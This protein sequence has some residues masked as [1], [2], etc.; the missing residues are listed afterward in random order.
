MTRDRKRVLV[1]GFGAFPGAPINPTEALVESLRAL[2]APARS[3]LDLH[4]LPVSWVETPRR[5]RELMTAVRPAVVLMFGLHGRARSVRIETRA[6][7]RTSPTASDA[8]GALPAS[9]LLCADGPA[10]RFSRCD[11]DQLL[12]AI[13]ATGAPVRL[14]RDAGTYLCNAALWTAL[15]GTADEVKVAFI[16]VPAT[17]RL[18]AARL[19]AVASAAI[20]VM[21]S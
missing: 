13:R 6:V 12:A 3:S 19:L 9:H 21:A 1:T 5:L 15:E 7:N 17:Q 2:P 18:T 20:G 10:T 16:H 14:S 8:A 4:V 11:R